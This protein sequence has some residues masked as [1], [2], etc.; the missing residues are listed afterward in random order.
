MKTKRVVIYCIFFK[1][2]LTPTKI[3]S[4]S[5]R[6][7]LGT[8]HDLLGHCNRR[9]THETAKELGW[10]IVN[11]PH[12]PCPSCTAANAKQKSVVE[13]SEHVKS[14]VS[15]ERIFTDISTVKNPRSSSEKLTHPNWLLI[16]VDEKTGT[17][18]SFFHTKQD[19]I[20]E[21]VREQFRKWESAGLPVKFAR[22]DNVGENKSAEK[23]ANG[24][25]WKLDITLRIYCKTNPASESSRR[26]RISNFG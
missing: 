3:A 23:A 11:S 18:L 8:A 24:R 7:E 19:D 20:V 21:P 14:K 22:Y 12:K 9:F 1:C 5:L 17:K 4:F 2:Q 25:L 10:M 26:I 6:L 15:N 16:M 13:V